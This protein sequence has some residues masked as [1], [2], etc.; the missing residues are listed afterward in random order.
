MNPG[1]DFEFPPPPDIDALLDGNVLET[2]D[3]QRTWRPACERYAEYMQEQWSLDELEEGEARADASR[4]ATIEKAEAEKQLQRAKRRQQAE[5][6]K[7]V[8]MA[9]ASEQATRTD[10]TY[11][12]S[13]L[14]AGNVNNGAFTVPSP[15]P[16]RCSTGYEEAVTAFQ[17][18]PI[19][20]VNDEA[21]QQTVFT[22]VPD[23]GQMDQGIPYVKEET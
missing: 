20:N 14:S 1:P 4:A 13:T 19:L 8:K 22:F 16:L 10:E 5:E 23:S 6:R 15:S 12:L 17:E 7:R 3:A 18:P 2:N 11:P 21:I 9:M